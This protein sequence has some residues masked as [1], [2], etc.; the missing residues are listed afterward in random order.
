MVLSGAD[1]G[2]YLRAAIGS[3]PFLSVLL[4]DVELRIIAVS[5]AAVEAHGYEPA[6]LVGSLVREVLPPGAAARVVPLWERAVRGESF[7]DVAGSHDGTAV[8]ET[9]FGPIVEDGTVVGAVAVVRDVTAQQRALAKLAETEHLHRVLTTHVGDMIAITAAEDGRYLWVSPSAREVT[10][11]RAEGLVGRRVDE[12]VHP[13]DVDAVRAGRERVSAGVDRVTTTLCRFRRPDGSWMW[14]EGRVRALGAAFGEHAALLTTVRDVGDRLQAQAALSAAQARFELAFSAAPVGMALVGADGRFLQ[15]NPALCVLLG[16]DVAALLATTFQHLTHPDDLVVDE[17]LLAE[18]LAGTREGY[19]LEKRYLRPDGSTVWALLA[20]SAVRE[21]GQE[22]FFISQVE[23]IT[24]RKNAL[25]EMERLATT[26]LLTGLPNRLLLMDRLRHA[27]AVA[28]RGGWLVG[29]LFLDL[30]RFKQVNDTFG[31]D[32]GDELLRQVGERLRWVTRDGDTTTRIGGDEFVLV[33]DHL[34]HPG[35][36]SEIG[37][38]VRNELARTFT[39]FGHDITIAVAVG[40][41]AGNSATAEAL[42]READR[43]MYTDKHRGDRDAAPDGGGD[44]EVDAYSAALEVL[45]HDQLAVHAELREGMDRGELRVFYQPIIDLRTGR[46]AAREALIRWAHPRRGLLGPD[47]FLAGTDRSRLGIALGE[48]VLLQA[49]TDAAAWADQSVA[50]VN[51][52]A[53]HLADPDLPRYVRRCLSTTGLTPDRLVLEITES[54]VLAASSSTLSCARQL[55]DLG[56][57]LSLD[58]FGTG[59]SSIAALHRLPIDS[60]K[61]DRSFV[62]DS[63]LNPTGAALVEGLIS[64]AA[65]MDL[66]VIAEGVETPEQSAWLSTRGCT[67]AQGFLYGRPAPNDPGG[68]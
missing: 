33:C 19:R 11:W 32:A 18:T 52:A 3:L 49:C 65:H 16:R 43:A 61:I 5:G 59:Y 15:V 54:L 51:L 22:P 7:V 58:D 24:A 38:R 55:A 25:R 13:A 57:G 34:D 21:P 28:R 37:D 68:I 39:V 23:D 56:V 31:H 60:F 67:F 63:T 27:L 45:A 66:D 53:R 12:V 6:R 9:S 29:V 44:R 2:H 8:Y 1:V 4:V 47:A 20:V 62:A 14:V 35:Q 46:Q 36:L 41:S 64:L 48:L 40:A 50:H 30:D 42:L 10:G 26:D 17:Q